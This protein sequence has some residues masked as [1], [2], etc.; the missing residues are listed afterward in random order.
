MLGLLRL[1]HMFGMTL[2][3]CKLTLK[4]G[5]NTI[6]HV[7]RIDFLEIIREPFWSPWEPYFDPIGGY[8]I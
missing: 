2:R 4:I 1:L 8:I 5:T 6:L 3:C 7:D